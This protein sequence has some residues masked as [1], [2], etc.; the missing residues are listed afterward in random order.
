MKTP[1]GKTVYIGS[2]VY[3]A[4]QELPDDVADKL[5]LRNG[6]V[7]KREPRKREPKENESPGTGGTG[8]SGE[9]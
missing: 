3:R 1:R 8:S 2:R 5:G 7:K 4:G 9:S 6:E